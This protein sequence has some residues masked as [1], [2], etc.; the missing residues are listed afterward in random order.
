[1]RRRAKLYASP[2]STAG[3]AAAG[4]PPSSC[5]HLLQLRGR[6]AGTEVEAR[7]CGAG[8]TRPSN[9]WRC[10][11]AR[12]LPRCARAL[13][14]PVR[15][16]L[17]ARAACA[18]AT[19]TGAVEELLL[20]LRPPGRGGQAVARQELEPQQLL[21]AARPRLGN[22]KTAAPAASAA[23]ARPGPPAGRSSLS[24]SHVRSTT[25]SCAM[26]RRRGEARGR[27]GGGERERAGAG[28]G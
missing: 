1:M 24:L 8:R 25:E 26:A 17:A 19:R 11:P 18:A 23:A 28:K 3:E 13:A 15:D 27:G 9:A 10:L 2:H 14:C 12:A 6:R 7:H 5:P 16:I 4:A 21:R 20:L 22:S